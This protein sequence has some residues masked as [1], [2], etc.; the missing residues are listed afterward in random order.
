M[1][2]AFSAL[3]AVVS[4]LV[5][6]SAIGSAQQDRKERS[7]RGW[8]GVSVQDVTK[9][10]VREYD[11][12][13]D[14]GA[15]VVRVVEKS[16]ADSVGIK[17][18]DVI[19]EFS[20]RRIYDADD[21]SKTVRR[22][23]PG[24]KTSVVVMR[25]ADKK[26]FQVAVGKLPSRSSSFMFRGVPRIRMF[27]S[28]R[29]LLGLSVIS[30]NEQLAEYF[31]APNKEGV[32]VEEVE[33]ESPAEKAGLKAGDVLLR[34]GSR[35]VSDIDDLRKALRKHESG[36][37]VEVE[38]L[39]KGSKKTMTV[40]IEEDSGEPWGLVIPDHPLPPK[41]HISPRWEEDA[42]YEFELDI[43]PQIERLE[44]RIERIGPMIEKQSREI[45]EKI[46]KQLEASF[47]ERSI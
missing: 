4:A 9:K 12:K 24:A 38:V 35:T 25:K 32:L 44:R 27:H 18:G 47:R 45:R 34:V 22:T 36:E 26:T 33:K 39:R 1:K 7:E 23:A 42:E 10:A 28:G 15:Y 16:P 21:L 19:V 8:L 43:E 40:E 6:T 17:S 11:L 37:K 41:V 5:L 20:G 29:G 31:G 30:L 2:R 13:T 46:N 3:A 14:D